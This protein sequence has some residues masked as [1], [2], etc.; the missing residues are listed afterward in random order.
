MRESGCDAFYDLCRKL[1]NVPLRLYMGLRV[2]NAPAPHEIRGGM[3]VASNHQS[4]LDPAA[5]AI[6]LDAQLSFLARD[7]LFRVP[8]FGGLIRKL[9][10]Q[11][12]KRGRTDAAALKAMM[13][14]LRGGG[15]LLMFP[16]GTRSRDGEMGTFRPGAAAVASR[17]GVPILPVCIEGAYRAWPRTALLP[18][19]ARVAVAY[20]KPIDTAGRGGDELTAELRRQIAGLQRFLRVELARLNASLSTTNM[21]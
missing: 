1:A 7:T 18:R 2:Y 21:D 14:I 20:G 5:V 15:R 8:L 10:S 19:R 9:G 6:G 16:E 4:F 13:R 17:C 11:P 3:L 12:V